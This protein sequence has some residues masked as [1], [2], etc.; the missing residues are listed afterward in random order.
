MAEAIPNSMERKRKRD[1]IPEGELEIDL[2]LPEP[3][4]KKALRKAKKTKS[5]DPKSTDTTPVTAP[6]DSD[7][8][9]NP[10]T[11]QPP[12]Q[13]SP[14]AIWIGNLPWTITKA[15]LRSFL[16]ADTHITPDL[17]T[18]VHMP[19]PTS[20]P[21]PGIHPSVAPKNK[22]FAYVDFATADAL[23]VALRLTETLLQGRKVLVKHASSFEGRPEPQATADAAEGKGKKPVSRR[24]FVG[25]LG[26]DVTQDEVRQHFEKCGVVEGVHVATFEDS[27][28][29]KGF[30][31]VTFADE[32]SAKKAVRGWVTD[33]DEEEGNDE[34]NG[35]QEGEKSGKKSK[36]RSVVKL[37]GRTMRREFAEDPTLR[38]HKRFGKGAK[39]ATEDEGGED[40]GGETLVERPK[41]NERPFDSANSKYP[42]GKISKGTRRE[43]QP[44]STTAQVAQ[45]TGAIVQGTG[46]KITFD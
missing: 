16:C 4:S 21:A 25:N 22:G 39:K 9:E 30:G 43:Y 33:D 34:D 11:Q 18:R 32:E 7:A 42:Q 36:R 20:K 24:V 12:K 8:E 2:A 35:E 41:R 15:D 28:K 37:N 1:A 45:L 17:I 19:P 23:A 38:Y 44:S 3:L 31:W 27:G 13:R 29:C 26:F 6:A 46:T 14:H 10:T 40:G 5:H